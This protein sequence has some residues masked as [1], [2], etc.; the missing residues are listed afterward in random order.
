[1]SSK[2]VLVTITS[3]FISQNL[4]AF[5]ASASPAAPIDA[6]LALMDATSN[7]I[8]K[9]GVNTQ[10]SSPCYLTVVHSVQGTSFVT[11][12]D[13]ASQAGIALYDYQISDVAHGNDGSLRIIGASSFDARIPGNDIKIGETHENLSFTFLKENGLVV[14][15][16]KKTSGFSVGDPSQTITCRF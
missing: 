5:S 12:D 10:T 8:Q 2:N 3:I 9:P 11:L 13:Q 7:N 15:A 16:I 1:M 14:T 4:L 6:V